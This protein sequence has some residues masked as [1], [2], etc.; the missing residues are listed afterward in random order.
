MKKAEQLLLS[1]LII[2]L[3]EFSTSKQDYL[4]LKLILSF[5]LIACAIMIATTAAEINVTI[6][7]LPLN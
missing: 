3:N 2:V 6:I 7:F 5:T 4:L 1:R